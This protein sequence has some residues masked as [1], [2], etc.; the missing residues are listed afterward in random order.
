MN[1]KAIAISV[2]TSLAAMFLF[3]LYKTKAKASN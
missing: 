3:D 2:G 1:Y